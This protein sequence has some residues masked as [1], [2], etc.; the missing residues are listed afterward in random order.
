M[1]TV[2]QFVWALDVFYKAATEGID[3]QL[4]NKFCHKQHV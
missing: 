2:S 1:F 3:I 4:Q